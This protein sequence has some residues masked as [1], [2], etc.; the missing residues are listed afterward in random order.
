[1]TDHEGK[2]I[3]PSST[4]NFSIYSDFFMFFAKSLLNLVSTEGRSGVCTQ[5]VNSVGSAALRVESHP[6]TFSASVTIRTAVLKIREIRISDIYQFCKKQKQRPKY[7][8]GDTRDVGT[9]LS[10][11][12]TISEDGLDEKIYSSTVTAGSCNKRQSSYFSLCI[13]PLHIGF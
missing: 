11:N 6:S 4:D 13:F 5:E 12:K 1:M 7:T 8:H 10:G 2:F 9:R 3:P